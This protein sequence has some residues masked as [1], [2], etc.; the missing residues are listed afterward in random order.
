V[1][2]SKTLVV[3]GAFN[4]ALA[5]ALSAL[6]AHLPLMAG[7]S[8]QGVASALEMHRFHAL[9]LVAAGVVAQVWPQVRGVAWAGAFMVLGILLF[10]VNLYARAWWGFDAL[11]TFVPWGGTAFIVGWGVLAL[12][13]A[14]SVTRSRP[15]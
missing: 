1:S 10:C 11:R 4:G 13:V 12:G 15:T 3:L 6:A 8:A 7:A 2:T 9:G 5:V 14:T